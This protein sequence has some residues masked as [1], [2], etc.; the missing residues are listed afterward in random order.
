MTMMARNTQHTN[1]SLGVHMARKSISS[2]PKL[3][4][5]I[6]CTRFIRCSLYGITNR[7]VVAYM[8]KPRAMT[9]APTDVIR[10]TSLMDVGILKNA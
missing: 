6:S 8:W 7:F 10:Q 9:E 5:S 1:L 4:Y 2:S 3:Y